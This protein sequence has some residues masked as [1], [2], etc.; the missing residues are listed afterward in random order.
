MK[1]K[2]NVKADARVNYMMEFTKKKKDRVTVLLR[3]SVLSPDC[4]PSFCL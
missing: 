2:M 3:F 4:P 1:K